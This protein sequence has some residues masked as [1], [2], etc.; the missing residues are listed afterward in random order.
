MKILCM[1]SLILNLIIALIV[2]MME[3]YRLKVSKE[4]YIGN[5]QI[6]DVKTKINY[7]QQEEPVGKLYLLPTLNWKKLRESPH[8]TN[9]LQRNWKR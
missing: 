3:K 2:D 1:Q 8:N 9:Q 4:I 5:A 6:V 7:I